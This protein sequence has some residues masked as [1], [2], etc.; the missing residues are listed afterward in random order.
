MLSSIAAQR[1]GTSPRNHRRRV[2]LGQTTSSGRTGTASAFHPN[3]STSPDFLESKR[4]PLALW[5]G[6]CD[7]DVLL[8]KTVGSFSDGDDLEAVRSQ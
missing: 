7:K 1:M 8:P 3:G 5:N 4:R 2:S 6:S